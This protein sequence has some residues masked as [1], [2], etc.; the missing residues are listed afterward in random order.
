MHLVSWGSVSGTLW[1]ILRRKLHPSVCFLLM[2]YLLAFGNK[3]GFVLVVEGRGQHKFA[4][5]SVPISLT[6]KS[7]LKRQPLENRDIKMVRVDCLHLWW[8]FNLACLMSA[9]CPYAVANFY[10]KVGIS[11]HKCA[12][13]PPHLRSLQ[14]RT[15]AE[16]GSDQQSRDGG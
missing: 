4:P 1:M 13:G 6:V 8:T 16:L 2:V 10:S 12:A 3:T 15:S 9:L 5:N 7:D 11:H 14:Q